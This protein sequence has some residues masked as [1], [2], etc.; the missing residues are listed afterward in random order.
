MLVATFGPSTGWAGKTITREGETFILQDHGP[1]SA[2]DVMSYDEQGHLVWASEGMRAWVGSLVS[3]PPIAGPVAQPTIG[4][5]TGQPATKPQGAPGIG[6]AGFVCVLVGLFVP[7]V[8][9]VGLVLSIVGYRQAKREDRPS[10]LALA[11]MVIG[12]VATISGLIL[13][14]VAVPMFLNQGNKAKDSAVK[15]GIHSIQIGVQMYA[16]DNNDS[17]PDPSLVSQS[18]FAS[19]VDFWPTNPYTG[20]PMAQG[21]GE[22]DFAYTVSADGTSF[23]LLGYG[24]GGK[25]VITVP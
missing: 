25:V 5:P 20:L 14:A 13:L 2:R 3:A 12:F 15:E 18:G 19:Y 10:G 11:G 8:G 17:Y 21:T 7:L 4:M 22:G 23:T 9:I 24:K 6:V 16:V 1:I